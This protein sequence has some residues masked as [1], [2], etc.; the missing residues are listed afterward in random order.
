MS[1]DLVGPFFYLVGLVSALS[2]ILKRER[3][4]KE[5]L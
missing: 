5:E 1:F 2:A 3:I 4:F